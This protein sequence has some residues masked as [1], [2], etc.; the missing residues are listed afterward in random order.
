[1]I[2]DGVSIR[3]KFEG[4]MMKPTSKLI[5]TLLKLDLTK[6]NHPSVKTQEKE[7]KKKKIPYCFHPAVCNP[8]CNHTTCKY[9][10]L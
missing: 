9:S 4:F 6:M 3:D 2:K 8:A 7:N 10:I 5:L 1:M